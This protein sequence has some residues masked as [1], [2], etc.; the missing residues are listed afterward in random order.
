MMASISVARDQTDQHIIDIEFHVLGLQVIQIHGRVLRHGVGVEG[1]RRELKDSGLAMEIWLSREQRSVIL[2]QRLVV[3]H[4]DHIHILPR[5]P[6]YD[7][8]YVP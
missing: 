1:I 6:Q 4:L 8:R 7:T 2:L 3:P 5:F